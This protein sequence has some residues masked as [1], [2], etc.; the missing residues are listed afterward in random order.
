MEFEMVQ[1]AEF[2]AGGNTF[3]SNEAKE[4]SRLSLRDV[5]YNKDCRGVRILEY[6]RGPLLFFMIHL[7]EQCVLSELDDNSIFL[8]QS[9]RTRLLRA[10]LLQPLKD[11]YTINTRLDCLVSLFC[12]Q[13]V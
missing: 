4:E 10:N 8:F 1:C 7:R 9:R 13:G 11:M 5:K 12:H 6:N 2:G 3:S